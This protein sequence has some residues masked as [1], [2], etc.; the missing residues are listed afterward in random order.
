MK[1]IVKKLRNV[2]G[3][4]LV[5][6][7]AA[8]LV[9]TLSVLLLASGAMAA[10]RMNRAARDHDGS[11][12]AALNYAESRGASAPDPDAAPASAPTATAGTVTVAEKSGTGSVSVSVLY[13]GGSGVWSFA[14][15]TPAADPGGAP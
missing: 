15:V 11:Y 7:L 13:Y 6:V 2:R 9:C 3:E 12:Y 1:R 10:A 8:V 14:A 5:E 4:S